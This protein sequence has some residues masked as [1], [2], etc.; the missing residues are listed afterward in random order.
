M[1][2]IIIGGILILAT[3][4][5][6][7]NKLVA[8]DVTDTTIVQIS[9]TFLIETYNGGQFVGE[10]IKQDEK[11]VIINT[12]DRGQIAIPKYEVK[13]IRQLKAGELNVKGD[14]LPEEVFS[15]RY[16]ITTNGLP[17]KKGENYVLW[18]IYG[19]EMQFGVGK[20]IGV[21]IMTSWIGMP[22]IGS[23]KFSINVSEKLNLGLGTLLGTGSWAAPDFVL[24]LPYGV[25]TYGD[26]RN[27]INFSGGYGYVAYDTE[28]G[29][30]ALISIAG[31]KKVGKKVSLVFDSFI[32]PEVRFTNST[33]NPNTDIETTTS[34][35][36]VLAI[37]IPGIRIQDAPDK[38]FQFGFAGVYGNGEM[39]PVPIPFLQWYRKF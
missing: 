38:A 3:V 30:K 19:P 36:S 8:Q 29:G 5:F 22:V 10:I 9:N 25:L 1:K 20:N 11:E 26:R 34:K 31:M 6:F 13:I 27:N 18:N 33:Y 15:T 7:N 21:G 16:F 32:V 14:Y 23:A 39:V 17:I 4:L 37:I 2:T 24:A 35:Y 12:K 28:G